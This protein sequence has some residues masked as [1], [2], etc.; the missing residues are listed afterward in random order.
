M[1][2]KFYCLCDV[3]VHC[4]NI[5]SIVDLSSVT[6]F[7]H[8]DD[9]IKKKSLKY[10]FTELKLDKWMFGWKYFFPNFGFITV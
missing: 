2:E 10:S 4:I 8:S 6:L 1:K 9:S 7:S 3:D 5:L